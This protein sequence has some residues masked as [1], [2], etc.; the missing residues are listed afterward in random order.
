MSKEELNKLEEFFKEKS[1]KKE[2]AIVYTHSFKSFFPD[3]NKVMNYATKQSIFFNLEYDKDIINKSNA[4]LT[5][6]S[7]FPGEKEILF[8]PFSSFLIKEIKKENGRFIIDLKYLG[9]YQNN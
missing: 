2:E 3:E 7:Y 4:D 5:D 6:I 1:N 9:I 8:F